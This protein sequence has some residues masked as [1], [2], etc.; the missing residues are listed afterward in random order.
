M[1][2]NWSNHKPLEIEKDGRWIKNWFSN[3]MPVKIDAVG[4][5]FPSVENAYQSFKCEN[6]EDR[7]Q[8]TA[9][10]PHKSKM[11]GRKIRIRKDWDFIRLLVMGKLLRMK[12]EQEPHRQQLLDTDNSV[13]V[14]W[15][16]WND[17]F[18]GADFE[19]GE[20]LN[21]LGLILMKIREEIKEKDDK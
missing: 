11:L 8:F 16:N 20:G 19:T 14:E 2:K 10:N 4:L 12:F 5:T 18:L 9:C 7:I 1:L 6:T 15:N 13:I 17:K 21:H 3:M